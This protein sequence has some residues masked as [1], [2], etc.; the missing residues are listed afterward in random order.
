M[1]ISPALSKQTNTIFNPNEKFYLVNRRSISIYC[2]KSIYHSKP[3]TDTKILLVY[4]SLCSQTTSHFSPDRGINNRKNT[5][6]LTCWMTMLMQWRRS[7][8]LFFH[9]YV[10]IFNAASLLCKKIAQCL[11]M[12]IHIFCYIHNKLIY[13]D[14]KKKSYRRMYVDNV[15]FWTNVL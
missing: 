6:L 12:M 15:C 11:G 3:G 1:K 5:P 4:L 8:W 7:N 13:W 14:W 10:V 2:S 9:A